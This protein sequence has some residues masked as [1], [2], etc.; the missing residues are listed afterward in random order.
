[1]N[2]WQSDRNERGGV[3]PRLHKLIAWD[4]HQTTNRHICKR[5][6]CSW[7]SHSGAVAHDKAMRRWKCLEN[8]SKA[9]AKNVE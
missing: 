2:F 6:G 5:L 4:G 9:A 7:Y 8:S 1:M 3:G